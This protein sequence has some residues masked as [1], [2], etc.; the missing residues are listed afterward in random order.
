MAHEYRV[1]AHLAGHLLGIER[2]A[3]EAVVLGQLVAEALTDG[4]GGLERSHLRTRH[5]SV[6]LDAEAR[7]RASDGASVLLALGG[8]LSLGVRRPVLGLG[9]SHQPDHARAKYTSP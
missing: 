4:A 5:A 1:L 7:Q 8:E 9:M 6:A 2:A 3:R